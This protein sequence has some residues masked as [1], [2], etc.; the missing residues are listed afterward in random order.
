MNA[1]KIR[2]K[3]ARLVPLNPGGFDRGFG[4]GEQVSQAQNVLGDSFVLGGVR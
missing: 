4:I 1:T 3:F 2:N